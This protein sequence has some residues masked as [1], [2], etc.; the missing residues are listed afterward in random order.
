MKDTEKN[1]LLVR[2]YLD[3]LYSK[4]DV[5]ALFDGMQSSTSDKLLDEHAPD[6]WE[7]SAFKQPSTDVEREQFKKEARLLLRHINNK[8]RFWLRKALLGFTGAAAVIC[9]ILGSIRF[10][11]Y[12][13]QQKISY[14]EVSTSY[15]QSKKIHLPDGT[16]LTLNSCSQ[17]RYPNRF[18]GEKRIVELEGEGYFRVHRNTAQPFL[19]KTRRMDIRVLGTC[20]NVKS[21][22]TDEIV[23]V[24]VESGKV[25]VDLPEAMLRLKAKEQVF[26]NTLSGEYSKRCEER[27]V[28]MWREGG[29]RFNSTPIRDVAKELERRYNCRITFAKGE[30]F[31]N[32]IS[33]EH[34]NQNLEAVL[35]SIEYTSGIRYRKNGNQILLYKY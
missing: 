15:G 22:F 6:I 8:R 27:S 9:L 34:D 2:R 11:D 20:F 7:E 16:E 10:F 14:L 32:L 1:K 23:S 17:I 21:Y 25:Q 35:Q 26:I 5:T 31:E 33:G 4:A 30:D 13:D 3:D 29:L 19:V 12:L 18:I 28:A 24:D